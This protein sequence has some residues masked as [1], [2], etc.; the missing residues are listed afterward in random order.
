M[1]VALITGGARGIGR[2]IA[3]D[4]GADQKVAFTYNT[5]DPGPLCHERPEF[6]AIHADLSKPEQAQKVI[7]QTIAHFGQLDVL[8]NNA[9][10]IAMN[11]PD[12][13]DFDAINDTFQV[14]VTAPMAL[15]AAALPYL[16]SGSAVINISSTNAV[17]PAMGASAYSASKAALNTW[18]RAMAKE[19]GSKGIRVNG[20][21]PGAT[22]LTDTPRPTELIAKFVEMTALGRVALPQDIAKAVRFLA[23]NDASFI[24]GEILNVNG[25]YRL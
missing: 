8:V 3:E 17:L 4:L 14:N 25:G 15:L 12:A 6:F 18:T 13:T 7:E 21:A 2:A 20:V 19:L 10:A 11:A 24:T 23:S 9:G 22:E 5:T 16:K 1:R